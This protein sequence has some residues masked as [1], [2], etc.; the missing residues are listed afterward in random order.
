MRDESA[1]DTK[2]LYFSHEEYPDLIAAG[3]VLAINL[4]N[5][6]VTLLNRGWDPPILEQIRMSRH[7]IMVLTCILRAYPHYCS[8]ESLLRCLYPQLSLPAEDDIVWDD[9]L[10]PVYR[11]VE[12]VMDDL[13]RVG[14][15]IYSARKKGYHISPASGQPGARKTTNGMNAPHPEV[16]YATRI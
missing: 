10:R 5:H 15:I 16:V 2:I 8:H 6:D 3:Q 4:A 11:A 1:P 9:L 7:A 14:L 13:P 12:K